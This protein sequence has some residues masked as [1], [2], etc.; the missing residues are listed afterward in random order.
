MNILTVDFETYYDK[1]YS[2]SKIT[3]EEY[4]RNPLFQVIG[5]SIKENDGETVWLSGG[6]D[7]L[8][9][10]LQEH[11][12]WENS[13]VLAHNTLFDGAILSWH[14]DVHPR[15]WLDTLCMARG[16]HGVEVGGSLAK[17]SERY[18][19]GQKGTEVINAL[20]K[21]REDF[22]E[23]ELSRYGDYCINDVELTYKLFHKLM[24]AGFPKQELKV[25]DMTLRMF[26]DPKLTLDL[27]RLEQHLDVLQDTKDKLLEECGIGKDELMS[28]NKFADALR[29]LDVVPPMKISP[30]T[31][32]ETYAFAKSDEAFKELQEH[33]NPKV[34][35]LVAARIGLKSTLEETRTE[36]FMGIAT[37]GALPVPI[38]Y[39]A[40]H[41][42][43]WGGC[44]VADTEVTVYNETNGVET[45]RIVDVLLNDLVWDGEEFVEH[46]GVQFSGYDKVI[47]WDGI[48]G[49][50]DHKVFTEV[51]EVSLSEAMQGA[52]RIE[53]A[54]S[55]TQDDVDSAREYVR[56]YKGED[57]V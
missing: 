19:L 35:A 4:I 33:E 51:G 17:L 42:G 39:Y 49:T 55:P 21:R 52:H 5:V 18:G 30:T 20:G 48:T 16:L 15:M 7:A 53:T 3:T 29:S 12:D 56:N 34:Q 25:I 50:A 41:T 32:K 2:L 36:R 31:G 57:T 23:D 40:A 45:K 43:R 1:E 6:F 47:E 14:F 38:K 22:S 44:L 24:A 8:K 27:A 10:Y 28:N 26:T 37:R 9:K 46:E 11:Y 13:A 54:R